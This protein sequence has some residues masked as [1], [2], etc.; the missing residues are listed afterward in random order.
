MKTELLTSTNSW[1]RV[2][3]FCN[4]VLLLL[5][6]ELGVEE[7]SDWMHDSTTLDSARSLVRP[8]PC[9]FTEPLEA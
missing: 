3:L 7:A 6:L 4:G 9:H 2:E 1:K 5:T 8:L